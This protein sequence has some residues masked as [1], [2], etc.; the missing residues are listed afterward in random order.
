MFNFVQQVNRF[1]SPELEQEFE[2]RDQCINQCM[3]LVWCVLAERLT[4]LL[5]PVC[6]CALCVCGVCR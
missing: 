3:C 6:V 1:V 5:G 4:Y 2:P